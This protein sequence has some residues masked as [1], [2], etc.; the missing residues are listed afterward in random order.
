MF[1]NLSLSIISS[2]VFLSSILTIILGLLATRKGNKNG[3]FIFSLLMFACSLYCMGYAFELATTNL[4]LMI[5]ALKFQY[6]GA[7]FIS[8]LMLLFTLK[9]TGRYLFVTKYFI[10]GLMAT[11]ILLLIFMVSN[12]YH[13]FFYI[14]FAIDST[15]YYSTL[16][17]NK[18]PIYW[19]HQF[20]SVSLSVS[21]FGLLLSIFY[22]ISPNFKKQVLFVLLGLFFPLATYIIY[23]SNL[24]PNHFDPIPLSFSFTG[25]FIYIG[26][27]GFELF[28]IVPIAYK[29]LFE[30][31]SGAVLVTDLTGKL[32]I[33]TNSTAQKMLGI[34]SDK[35]QYELHSH[36]E[37]WPEL[38]NLILNSN[39]ASTI[40]FSKGDSNEKNWYSASKS[41]ITDS[42]KNILG[43]LLFIQNINHQKKHELEL[44]QARHEAIL[45][46]KAKS[47]FLANMSHE[48]RT[49]LNGVIG[50]TELL[51]QTSL[52]K[53]QKLYLEN[54]ERS[55]QSLLNIINDILDFSK[56]EAGKLDLEFVE[57]DLFQLLEDTVDIIKLQADQKNIDFVLS[58]NTNLPEHVTLDPIRVKQILINLLANAVK[59]TK[60]GEIIFDVNFSAIDSTIGILHFSIK[61]TGIGISAEHQNKLFTSFSQ[62][63]TSTTRKYGGT[64]LGLTISSMLVSK[65][66]SAIEL[67]SEVDKGSTFSFSISVEY[68]KNETSIF[69]LTST[70][71]K[72]VLLVDDNKASQKVLN[73]YLTKIGIDC[74]LAD[75]GMQVIN[76]LNK[77]NRYDALFIDYQMPDLNGLETISIIRNQL[78]LSPKKL[79]IVLLQGSTIST[80]LNKQI[81]EFGI[82]NTLIKPIKISDFFQTIGQIKKLN[83]SRRLE[84]IKSET[85][86][87]N[88]TK[89]TN[90]NEYRPTILLVEDVKTNMLLLENIMHKWVENCEIVEATN[91]KIAI[92][93]YVECLPDIIIMDIQMPEMDGLEATRAIRKLE[94]STDR[95]VPIIALTAGT[96]KEERQKCFDAGMNAYLQKPIIF[97]QLIQELNKWS[98]NSA[99]NSAKTLETTIDLL[100]SSY[101]ISDSMKFNYIKLFQKV[102]EDKELFTQ[103]IHSLLKEIPNYL[104]ELDLAISNLHFKPIKKI[105]HTI[106]GTASNVYI[107]ELVSLAHELEQ[108]KTI[109]EAS[110]VYKRLLDKWKT[111]EIDL[112]KSILI[113]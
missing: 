26:L 11:P 9:Y 61:D 5:I 111:I 6:L 31:L 73:R 10:W 72:K 68:S 54:A 94:H 40:E 96:L 12:E 91:G 58:L 103:I 69:D 1:T 38:M 34:H 65:M 98:L 25:I 8:P 67:V 84:V 55:A 112:K 97:N 87:K 49:P 16:N 104:E 42:S 45:A 52:D 75:N 50:F 37:D 22:D 35:Q 105:A 41:D 23:L 93:K 90:S 83:Y 100:D 113:S 21:S 56:I 18:G 44:I 64:G 86:L 32:L 62:A 4:F 59:F 81:F 110:L 82:N 57:T 14:S 24:I 102:G 95:N 92:Q 7:V 71:I 2:L 51:A 28:K 63:D 30:N 47:E 3:E 13:H 48:I 106:K 20:Y 109:D 108:T 70:K 80:D 78:Q 89:K 66:N 79:P 19:I 74:T 101:L 99:S 29:S 85:Y 88:T 33:S 15:E 39:S 46:N 77:G 17:S 107:S 60:V 36:L 76:Y 53:M 43:K 27:F